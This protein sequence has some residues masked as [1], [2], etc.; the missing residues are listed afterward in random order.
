MKSNDLCIYTGKYYG[1]VH[2]VCVLLSYVT[3]GA[4]ELLFEL[5]EAWA[6]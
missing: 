6:E 5:G 2:C 1:E 3:Q 4:G